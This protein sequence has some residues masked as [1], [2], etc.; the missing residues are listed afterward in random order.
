VLSLYLR[1]TEELYQDVAFKTSING[2]AP[3]L[4]YLKCVRQT[5]KIVGLSSYLTSDLTTVLMNIARQY[6]YLR[7]KL[8]K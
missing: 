7:S 4:S 5:W 8:S 3:N 2:G 1:A 6:G